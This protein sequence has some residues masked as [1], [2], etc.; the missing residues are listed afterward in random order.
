MSTF[1]GIGDLLAVLKHENF[2]S[3]KQGY[4]FNNL[5]FAFKNQWMARHD[6]CKEKT[7]HINLKTS[8]NIFSVENN[9][10]HNVKKIWQ[11]LKTKS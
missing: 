9:F 2:F 6:V 3:Y 10:P 5:Q 1:F 4:L 11:T 8:K 7:V